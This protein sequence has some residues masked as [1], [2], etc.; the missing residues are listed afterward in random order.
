[1]ASGSGHMCARRMVIDLLTEARAILAIFHTNASRPGPGSR[2]TRFSSLAAGAP[3]ERGF[4][5]IRTN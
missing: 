3:G 4:G 1:M 2:H 5:H